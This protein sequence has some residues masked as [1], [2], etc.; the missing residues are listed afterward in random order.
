MVIIEKMC[1]IRNN[2][3]SIINVENDKL[4]VRII[5][6]LKPG[7]KC[8]RTT[9]SSI[10]TER[11]AINEMCTKMELDKLNANQRVVWTTMPVWRIICRRY[12]DTMNL[13]GSREATL[14]EHYKHVAH[15]L[16]LGAVYGV[17]IA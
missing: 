8:N 11:I 10:L 14:I 2:F 1:Q 13:G 9:R 16:S 12:S 17:S 4:Y 7:V 3:V 15:M 6:C 5:I